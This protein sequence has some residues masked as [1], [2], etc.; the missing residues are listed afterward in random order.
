MWKVAGQGM[1]W[2]GNIDHTM[3][4][5]HVNGLRIYKAGH[6]EFNFDDEVVEPLIDDPIT[7]GLEDARAGRVSRV[8]LK[9]L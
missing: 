4:F 7:R 9:E 3:M 5:L 6:R 8:N 2:N 1:Q